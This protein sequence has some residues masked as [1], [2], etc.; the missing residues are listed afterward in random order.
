MSGIRPRFHLAFAVTDLEAA[1]DFYTT[2]LGCGVG[3]R[4]PRWIDFDFQ[5]H[6][7]TAHLVDELNATDTNPVDGDRVPAR[8]FGLIL[9]WE[10][11]QAL[12]GRLEELGTDFL[13]E[14]KIR[15]PGR[16]GEQATLFLRDPAGNALE[17]KSFRDDR[18]IFARETAGEPATD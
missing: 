7:I 10:E 2:V 16:A 4:A 11:W 13:I 8:H 5:G 3:R 18:Q 15:F 6:Q 17:F 12:A 14:P 9:P 1:R